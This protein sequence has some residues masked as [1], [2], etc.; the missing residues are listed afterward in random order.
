[1]ARLF[2]GLRIDNCHSTPL[3][4]GQVCFC[5]TLVSLTA[6]VIVTVTATSDLQA[7]VDRARAV[8]PNLFTASF[9]IS[10]MQQMILFSP[11]YQ[12]RPC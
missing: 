3:H 1:M 11:P 12:F 4:V 2:D 6:T 9:L 5:G 10:P 8:N 7:M